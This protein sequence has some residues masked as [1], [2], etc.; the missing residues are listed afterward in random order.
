MEKIVGLVMQNFISIP[1]RFRFF[2]WF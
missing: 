2:F 1:I